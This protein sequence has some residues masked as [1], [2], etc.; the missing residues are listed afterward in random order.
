VGKTPAQSHR[1]DQKHGDH[2]EIFEPLSKGRMLAHLGD[3]FFH[4]SV[5][6][7]FDPFLDQ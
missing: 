1:H 3:L 7:L 4:L 5:A 2:T 6:Y